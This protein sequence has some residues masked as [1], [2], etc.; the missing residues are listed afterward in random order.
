[1]QWGFLKLQKTRLG[2]PTT[3]VICCLMLSLSDKSECSPPLF[4]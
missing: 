2:L 1:M 3:A 4:A